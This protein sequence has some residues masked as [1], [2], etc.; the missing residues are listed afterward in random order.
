M[1]ERGLVEIQ[2]PGRKAQHITELPVEIPF[3]IR[4][5]D[6]QK[7]HLD[8]TFMIKIKENSFL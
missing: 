4:K 8:I 1:A 2:V 3:I 6:F 5:K 7:L